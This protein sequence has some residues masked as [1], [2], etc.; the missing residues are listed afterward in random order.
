MDRENQHRIV[1]ELLSNFQQ[2]FDDLMLTEAIPPEWDGL[3]LR[4]LVFDMAQQSRA[5]TRMRMSPHY[6]R[7]RKYRDYLLT[8]ALL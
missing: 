3:E 2:Q 6:T 4:E 5:L 8:H 1:K 7:F